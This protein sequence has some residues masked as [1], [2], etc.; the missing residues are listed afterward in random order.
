MTLSHTGSLWLKDVILP[1]Y[2]TLVRLHLDHY[3]QFWCP[4]CKKDMK[5]LEQ[6]QRRPQS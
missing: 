4:Q 2:S 6:V 1:L 5:L 3:V